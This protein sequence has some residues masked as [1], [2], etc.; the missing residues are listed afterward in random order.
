MVADSNRRSVTKVQKRYILSSHFITAYHTHPWPAAGTGGADHE[1][2]F[3]DT[4]IKHH[5]L[6]PEMRPQ[7]TRGTAGATC[8]ESFR[9]P[10]RMS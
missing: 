5:L 7:S 1:P 3:T 2:R 9:S 8:G 6:G 10:E 4:D